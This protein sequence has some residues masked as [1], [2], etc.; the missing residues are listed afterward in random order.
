MSRRNL[1]RLGLAAA[2]AVFPLAPGAT[3]AAVAAP[4]VKAPIPAVTVPYYSMN[5]V[6]KPN[7]Q[8]LQASVRLRVIPQKS[9][10]KTLSLR[11]H[12][13]LKVTRVLVGDRPARHSRA[14]E[15]LEVSLPAYKVGQKLVA[16]VDYA[17]RPQERIGDRLLQD[18]GADVAVL[19]PKGRW[20]PQPVE[21]TPA[22]ASVHLRLPASWKVAGPAGRQTFDKSQHHLEFTTPGPIAVVAGPFQ[23]YQTAGLTTYTRPKST[24]VAELKE[25]AAL[26]GYY[27]GKGLAFGRSRGTLIEL[28]ERYRAL[29]LPDWQARPKSLGGLA[30]WVGLAQWTAPNAGSHSHLERQWLGHSLLAF[31]RALLVEAN[32]GPLAYQRA[33]MGHLESYQEFLRT[34]PGEDAPLGEPIDP[35]SLAWDPVVIHKGALVWAMLRDELGDAALWQALKH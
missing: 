34:A 31:T 8:Q 11:L 21:S 4:A 19:H 6:L 35:E 22:T 14:G 23:V 29:V 15:S 17:G 33:L 27:R 32:E 25:G 24:V 10:L 26:L 13:G 2:I 1:V 28:P 16:Q 18:T 5:L 30:D 9:G 3:P 20:Y 12:P 7:L